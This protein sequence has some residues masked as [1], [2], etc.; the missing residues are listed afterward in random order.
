MKYRKIVIGLMLLIPGGAAYGQESSIQYLPATTSKIQVI[1]NYKP[2]KPVPVVVIEGKESKFMAAQ[3]AKT[4]NPVA[5]AKTRPMAPPAP[6]EVEK[7]RVEL[8]PMA[9]K[10]TMPKLRTGEASLPVVQIK[11]GNIQER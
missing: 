10:L 5:V 4:M 11:T 6:P 7:D 8:P 2:S 1:G 9:V 3:N